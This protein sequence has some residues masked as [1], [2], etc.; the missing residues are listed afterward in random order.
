MYLTNALLFLRFFRIK[1]RKKKV[2]KGIFR[3]IF[4]VYFDTCYK[5]LHYYFCV[6]F[7]AKIGNKSATSATDFTQK[8][9]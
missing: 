4:I 7:V 2:S 5:K 9:Y 1:S 6:F 3:I 8:K